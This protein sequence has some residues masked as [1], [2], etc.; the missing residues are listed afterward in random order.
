M[1]NVPGRGR[2][3]NI[4][5]KLASAKRICFD[6]NALIYHLNETKPYAEIVAELL[7]AVERG[8]TD[9][10]ISVITELEVLVRPLREGTQ[11]D[12]EQA[13]AV[14]EAPGMHV[15]EMDRGI[16]RRAAE[17]RA[18]SG[19]DLADAVIVATALSTGCDAIVGNDERCAQRVREVPYVLLDDLVKEQ[20]P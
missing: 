14:L 2:G 16:A 20:Q 17:V 5:G 15:I 7:N 18:A 1:G 8:A 11:W 12:V 9:G 10:I 13:Q 19:V 4:Q 6:S 3:G